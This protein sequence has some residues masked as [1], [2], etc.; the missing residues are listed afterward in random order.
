M[1]LGPVG[2]SKGVSRLISF[3]INIIDNL[4]VSNARY[5]THNPKSVALTTW[6]RLTKLQYIHTYFKKIQIIIVNLI[7]I[8]F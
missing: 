2:K 5:P 8:L 6:P 3:L 7:A 4:E 1:D